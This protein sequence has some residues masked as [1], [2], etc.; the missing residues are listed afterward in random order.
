M[1]RDRHYLGYHLIQPAS[2]KNATEFFK[3]THTAEFQKLKQP[4]LYDYPVVTVHSVRN[5]RAYLHQFYGD[6]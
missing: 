6:H 4:H 1:N 3:P 5:G 2:K